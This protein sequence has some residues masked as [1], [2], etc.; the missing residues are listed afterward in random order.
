[1]NAIDLLL[2]D[3][4][5]TEKIFSEFKAAT[6]NRWDELFEQ[7]YSEL[8][9]HADLEEH[10]FY[11]ALARFAA[12]KVDHSIDEHSTVKSLLAELRECD[13]GDPSYESR[14]SDLMT[15]VEKH[16]REEEGPAGLMNLAQQNLDEASL[17]RMGERMERLK[18]SQR[19][20]A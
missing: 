16:I 11:P 2:H 1:M 12:D 5:V 3:H 9:T 7:V 18:S 20:A 14:F 6:A 15:E 17:M 4:R 19:K 13:K 8:T 10:E